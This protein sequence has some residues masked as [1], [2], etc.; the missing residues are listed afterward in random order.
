MKI[1]LFG[2]RVFVALACMVLVSLSAGS[3]A[4]AWDLA[5]HAFIEENLFKKQGQSNAALLLHRTYGAGVLDLANNSFSLPYLYFQNYLHD[6][7]QT[8]FMKAWNSAVDPIEKAAAYGFVGH[9]NSWG[10]DSTAHISGI[11]FGKEGGYVNAKARELA[12]MLRPMLSSPGLGLD[13]P[14]NVLLSICHYLVEAGV[15]LLVLNLDPAVGTKLMA[16]ADGRSDAVP[17]LLV[18]SFAG[19]LAPVTGSAEQAEALVRDAENGFRTYMWSHGFA[20]TQPNALDLVAAELAQQAGAY[21]DYLGVPRLP[22]NVSFLIAKQGIMASMW[23]CA[24]DFEG[25]LRATT[26]WVNGRLSSEAIVW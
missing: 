15:D 22:F 8:N 13:L 2:K 7:A 18:R 12:V 10:M 25:E 4:S 14:D 23:L 5:A 24:G 6:P 21:F 16:A 20:L 26:G 9:N 11:T 19:D 1:C 17:A 3:T